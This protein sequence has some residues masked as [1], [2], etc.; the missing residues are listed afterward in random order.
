MSRRGVVTAI[1][2]GMAWLSFA[3][4]SAGAQK[5]YKWTDK[6]GKVHFSNVSPGGDGAAVD[7]SAV[8]GI[9]ASNPEP[10]A[11]PPAPAQGETT[12][13]AAPEAAPP[14]DTGSSESAISEEAFSS[15]VSMTRSR[16]KRE[17]AQA[18]E[19]SQAAGEKLE[20]LKKERDQ[21]ARIGLETLQK[22]Y[23]PEQHEVSQEDE[24]RKQKEKADKRVDE[25]RKEYAGLHD[26]AVKRLGH[27][28]GWG[29]PIE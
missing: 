1:V 11:P 4:G 28:P 8:K 26:E 3:S 29:L 2:M 14:A 16:L 15:K 18:K 21:P 10:P 24:L 20:A 5:V 13:Q 25:I 22:A 7:S 6:D 17:L 9:E 27:Q 12:A 23:G 19:E